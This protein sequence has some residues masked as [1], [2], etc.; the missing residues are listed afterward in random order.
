MKTEYLFPI[1]CAV[2]LA[3]LAGGSAARKGDDK[4]PEAKPVTVAIKSLKFDPKKLEVRAGDSVVWANESKTKHTATS[5]DD[6]KTFDSGEI[7]PDRSSKP[8][9]FEREGE[10]R[11]HCKVHGKSMSGTIVVKAKAN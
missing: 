4:K 6:G 9:T 11:Y 8:V 3:V 2:C 1:V 5:D 7:E 10:F